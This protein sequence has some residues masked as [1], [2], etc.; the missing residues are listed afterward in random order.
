MT[1]E[2][3]HYRIVHGHPIAVEREVN[4]LLKRGW[5]LNGKMHIMK[6]PGNKD[7]DIVVQSVV[8]EER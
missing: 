2:N 3:T 8:Y 6:A 7:I 4:D 1:N 5:E